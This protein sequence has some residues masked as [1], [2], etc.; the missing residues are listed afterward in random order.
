[1]KVISLKCPACGGQLKP[2][3]K[4]CPLKG[5][6]LQQIVIGRVGWSGHEQED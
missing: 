1:M 2:G 6:P 4:I 3:M 5:R